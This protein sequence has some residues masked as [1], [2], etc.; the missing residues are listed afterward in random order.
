MTSAPV[1]ELDALLAPIP[2]ASPAGEPHADAVRRELDENRREPIKG[3]KTT[4]HW[5]ADWTKVLRLTT[6][7][8]TGTGK[9]VFLAVRLVE[10]ATKLHGAAGLRDGLRLLQ[11]LFEECWDRMH[12]VPGDGDT[13]DIRESHVVWLNDGE[14]GGKFPKTVMGVPLLQVQTGAF[15]LLDSQNKELKTAFNEAVAAAKPPE[16]E[17]LR[18]THADLLAARKA[19]DDL[20]AAL[21]KRRIDKDEAPNYRPSEATNNLGYA[22]ERCIEGTVAIAQMRNIELVPPAEGEKPASAATPTAGAKPA[23]P[24][25]TADTRDGLYRQIQEIAAALQR[26]E[27]HSPIP[28]LLERCVKLGKLPFPQLMRA[29]VRDKNTLDELDRLLGIEE[30]EKEKK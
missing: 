23:T 12:P 24:A 27:P 13:T 8:L 22:I 5:K 15:S 21:A 3:D 18:A 16:L 29:M 20:A 11:R 19:L 1:L 17:K 14:K 28:Y 25:T 26:M 30:K 4:E 9:D 10:A 2:G 6:T 7:A